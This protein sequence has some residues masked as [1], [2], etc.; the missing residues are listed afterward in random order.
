MWEHYVRDT[1]VPD[2]TPPPSPVGIR[3][4]GNT[5][6]WDAEADVESGLAGFEIRLKEQDPIRIP[7][8]GKNR[9]GRPLF[10]GLQ[11]SDTPVTPLVELRWVDDRLLN[12]S[13]SDV[14]LRAV[15]TVG[16]VSQ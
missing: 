11:Y 2:T 9:F 12:L 15:N 13:V 6:T 16:L 10:Q 3:L 7:A 4:K 5:L 14:D 8:K 1:N